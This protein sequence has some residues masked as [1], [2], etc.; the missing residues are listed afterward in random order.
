MI[1]RKLLAVMFITMALGMTA[2]SKKTDVETSAQA[3]STEATTAETTAE[4]ESETETESEV[5]DE[6]YVDGTI[7]AIS[8]KIITVKN[9]EDEKETKYD[10]TDAQVNNEFDLT[11]GDWVE[12]IFAEGATGDVIPAIRLEVLTSILE[13][14]MD[15]SITGTIEEASADTI[16]IKDEAGESFDISIVNAYVVSKDGVKQGIEATVTYLGDLGDE[17]T[18]PMGI[19]IVTEDSYDSDEAKLN[20]ISGTVSQVFEGVLT[21]ELADGSQFNFNSEDG[22]VDINTFKSGDT[23]TFTYEGSLAAKIVPIT[24]VINKHI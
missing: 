10:L 18:L 7:T 2:C 17:E 15:A 16:K 20:A 24:G 11:E 21:L 12:V 14:S 22:S 6:D 23:V 19:K 9:D 8:G 1:K 5:V 3:A 13:E 4:T